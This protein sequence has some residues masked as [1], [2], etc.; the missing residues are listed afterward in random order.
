MPPAHEPEVRERYLAQSRRPLA[1]ALFVFLAV[2]ALQV[3]LWQTGDQQMTAGVLAFQWIADIFSRLDATRVGWLVSLAAVVAPL[4]CHVFANQPWHLRK[5][6]IPAMTAESAVL[7]L[8]LLAMS[9]VLFPADNV[10]AGSTTTTGLLVSIE[11]G[12]FEELLFR[13]VGFAIVDMLVGTAVGYTP[14]GRRITLTAAVVV[15]SLCFAAYHHVPATGEAWSWPAFGFRSLS[16]A[17]LGMVFLTR[18][19]GLAVGCHVAYNA[20]VVLLAG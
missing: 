13:L 15:T 11:A 5:R 17:W 9:L 1:S 7:A 2:V 10:L 20:A 3:G 8:P 18:G 6:L 4:A 12:I 19:F 16:G 14:T